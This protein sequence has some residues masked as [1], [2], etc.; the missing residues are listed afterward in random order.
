MTVLLTL[1]KMTGHESFVLLVDE[2][3]ATVSA[4]LQRRQQESYLRSLRLL[5]DAC[6][7]PSEIPVLIVLA[8]TGDASRAISSI[9]PA[10]AER[11]ITVDLPLVD[12]SLAIEVIANYLNR[13]R[14][15]G[16]QPES[17]LFPLSNDAVNALLEDLSESERSLRSLLVRC[18]ALI[19][20]LAAHPDIDLPAN[21]EAVRQM[22]TWSSRRF[23]AGAKP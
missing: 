5:C 12:R 22:G 7:D 14:L 13:D 19:E 18:Q 23:V 20:Y 16:G 1:T 2:F 17:S 3:E 9:Y 4:T 6:V 15:N 21:V 11:L 10:L 8:M